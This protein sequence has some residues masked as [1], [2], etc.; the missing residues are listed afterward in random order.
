M[1]TPGQS[2][3]SCHCEHLVT[4]DAWQMGGWMSPDCVHQPNPWTCDNN[5]LWSP[6]PSQ[7]SVCPTSCK[8]CSPNLCPDALT[9]TV[10]LQIGVSWDT[11][12]SCLPV[13]GCLTAHPGKEVSFICRRWVHREGTG[14][15]PGGL[16]SAA[17]HFRRVN[18]TRFRRTLLND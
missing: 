2:L 18:V 5:N 16:S 13:A 3:R 15:R 8:L 1:C 9:Y 14:P 12:H 10:L 11:L 4:S 6:S 17:T 7:P